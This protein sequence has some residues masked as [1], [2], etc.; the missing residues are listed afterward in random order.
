MGAK[1]RPKKDDFLHFL[2]SVKGTK[3]KTPTKYQ[4]KLAKDYLKR[5]KTKWP[6]LF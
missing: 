2:L 6:K 3:H 1:K 5:G 4:K